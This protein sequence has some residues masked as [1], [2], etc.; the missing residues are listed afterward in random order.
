LQLAAIVQNHF[1][2]LDH[3]HLNLVKHGAMLVAR[4]V[5]FESAD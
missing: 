5:G 4:N 1:V 3:G 2:L